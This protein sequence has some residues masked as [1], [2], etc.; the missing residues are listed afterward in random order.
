MRS[1]SLCFRESLSPLL[2]RHSDNASLQYSEYGFVTETVNGSLQVSVSHSV[3]F[4]CFHV[5][6]NG[7][8]VKIRSTLLRRVIYFHIYSLMGS[9]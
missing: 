1:G 4:W 9:L 5:R 7:E 6:D 3:P 2:Y 8:S